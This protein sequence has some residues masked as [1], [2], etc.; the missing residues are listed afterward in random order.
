MPKSANLLRLP[1]PFLEGGHFAR[2]ISL[3]QA[4]ATAIFAIW[5]IPTLA[6]LG[7]KNWDVSP[8]QP[9]STGRTEAHG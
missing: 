9:M 3:L 5:R 2:S 1:S 7:G 6:W 4:A 8:S